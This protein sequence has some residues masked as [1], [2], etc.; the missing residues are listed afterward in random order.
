MRDEI[1]KIVATE[2]E[3]GL[4]IEA[5]RAEADRIL[6]EAQK[7][8]RDIIDQAR[9]EAHAES[10]KIIDSATSLAEQEKQRRLAEAAV[11]IENQI[12]LDPAIKKSATEEVIR[13]VCRLTQ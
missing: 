4:I 6:S 12:S 13:H 1:Q 10:L 8:G 5:A 3:A 11:E 2:S 7:R 9:Q